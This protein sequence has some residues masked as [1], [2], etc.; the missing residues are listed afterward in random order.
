MERVVI[1]SAL[2]EEDP[3]LPLGPIDFNIRQVVTMVISLF[4]WIGIS[5]VMVQPLLGLTTGFSLLATAW[6]PTLGA[7]FAFVR[8]KG[9]PIDHWIGQKI[10]FHFS[11][12]TFILKEPQTRGFGGMSNETDLYTDQDVDD[13]I[14][15]L[16]R[17]RVVA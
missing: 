13:M 12:R 3:F 9:R 2:N 1:P 10:S 16:D 8:V 6:L 4:M 17:P 11:A 15:F 14:G 5:S 7:I